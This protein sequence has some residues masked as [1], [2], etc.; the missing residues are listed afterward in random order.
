MN[1]HARRAI[2]LTFILGFFICAPIL[3]LYT[4]GYRYNFK[5]DT[6]QR[7]GAIVI[8]TEPRG[9]TAY[10]NNELM[11]STT[12]TRLNNILPDEYSIRLEKENYYPW[13]KKLSVKSQETTFAENITL[14]PKID[15]I[16]ISDLQISEIQFS[17]NQKYAIFKT[18]DFNQDYLY[19]L[20][21][22]NLNTK[23]I[24]NDNSTFSEYTTNWAN[25]DSKFLFTVNEQTFLTN[26]FFPYQTIDLTEKLAE[27]K[28]ELTN[29]KWHPHNASVVYAQAG[30]SIY[31]INTITAK[32]E[33]GF[34]L[35]PEETLLDFQ[36]LGDQVFV[37]ENIGQKT[38]LTSYS[39]SEN[40]NSNLS[41]ELNNDKLKF[42][43]LYGDN[44]GLIDQKNK[45][46]YIFNQG[47]DKI[48]FSKQNIENL[49]LHNKDLLLLQTDQDLEY[50]DLNQEE[51]ISK[52]ITRYSQGLK[53][54]LWATSSANYVIT[55]HQG[56]L[57]I[58]ELDDRDKRF[59]IDLPADNVASFAISANHENLIFLANGF[60]CNI[61][62][63][64]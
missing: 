5:K 41:I 37:I 3:I 43:R 6:V 8:E 55:N 31:K 29:F 23:L 39:L 54:A 50:I 60:L 62:L 52:N 64:D 56:N 21:L 1:I 13:Q 61:L 36:V 27:E 42:D 38:I 14:F 59:I 10:L 15:P 16:Q 34:K 33:N 7:T 24:F 46:F 48:L 20:N 18:H 51:L 44:L 49:H 19:L 57:Y 26:N 22:N 9:A 53:S 2:A 45:T 32:T 25:D 40:T 12:S 47:L 30:N 63:E 58:I 17:N 4:S 11:D 28:L 35:P